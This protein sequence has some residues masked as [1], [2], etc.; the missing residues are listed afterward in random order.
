M[1]TELKE[2]LGLSGQAFKGSGTVRVASRGDRR[3]IAW[4]LAGK[5]YK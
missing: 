1:E 2:A 4:S 3:K 5:K